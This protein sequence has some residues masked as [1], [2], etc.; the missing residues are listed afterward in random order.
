MHHPHALRF[1]TLRKNP[2]EGACAAPQAG[3]HI[4]LQN[5]SK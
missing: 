4:T 5:D 2:A 3:S 1:I